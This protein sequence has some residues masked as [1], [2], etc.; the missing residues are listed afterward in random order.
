[1]PC[2]Q[3]YE[4]NITVWHAKQHHYMELFEETYSSHKFWPILDRSSQ[5][6]WLMKIMINKMMFWSSVMSVD[7]KKGISQTTI[8][9]PQCFNVILN[10]ALLADWYKY[11]VN[12]MGRVHI[13]TECLST[14]IRQKGRSSKAANGQSPL[15]ITLL[16]KNITVH[17]R[18]FSHSPVSV[19]HVVHT[20][21]ALRWLRFNKAL[22][23]NIIIQCFKTRAFFIDSFFS[24]ALK[25]C[26]QFLKWLS[27]FIKYVKWIDQPYIQSYKH[28]SQRRKR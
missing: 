4:C 10:I 25:Q 11:L 16:F 8:K 12:N 22:I 21:H 2:D 18:L 6:H 14:M 3:S 1:M 20:I 13:N 19:S 5:S 15:L 27:F 23:L 28:S 17:Q 9:V 7:D 26:I 24:N